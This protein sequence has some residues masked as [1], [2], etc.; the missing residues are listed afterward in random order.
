MVRAVKRDG[1][2]G[3]R[4]VLFVSYLT[5]FPERKDQGG[6]DEMGDGSIRK[7]VQSVPN[8]ESRSKEY[9]IVPVMEVTSE[10]YWDTML[11]ILRSDPDP[12]DAN[13]RVT[14]SKAGYGG[15]REGKRGHTHY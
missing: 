15:V 13:L 7:V 2:R 1:V 14:W 3:S 5:S 12:V 11:G 4:Y 9:T 10:V 8:Q 6:G